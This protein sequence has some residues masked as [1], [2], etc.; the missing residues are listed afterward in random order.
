MAVAVIVLAGVGFSLFGGGAKSNQALT[1]SLAQNAATE[2]VF[3]IPNSAKSPFI[4][5]ATGDRDQQ[6]IYLDK[7][8][9][10]RVIVPSIR[11]VVDLQ[12]RA[13]YLT[14]LAYPQNAGS[15]FFLEVRGPE[16]KPVRYWAMNTTT[17]GFHSLRTAP[18]AHGILSPTEHFVAY[19]SGA[20]EAGEL[21]EVHAVGLMADAEKPL[22]ILGG[23]ETL[24][25]TKNRY[26]GEPTAKIE[27]KNDKTI[28]F[29][30]TSIEFP[31]GEG[32]PVS[33]TRTVE[34][35]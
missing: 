2:A 32:R 20:D 23:D 26:T 1:T 30:V 3:A 19:A 29:G 34:V 14:L 15:L 35:K 13:S 25:I 18:P 33:E 4:L 8:R 7:R 27:W 31:V 21:R 17:G 5:T 6:L 11:A 9:G 10:S 22:A 12:D 16:Q 28:E 24:T